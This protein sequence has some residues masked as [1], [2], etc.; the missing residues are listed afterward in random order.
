MLTDAEKFKAV[1]V[2]I[3]R[4]LEELD[5]VPD[6]AVAALEKYDAKYVVRLLHVKVF[7][8]QNALIERLREIDPAIA[9]ELAKRLSDGR[10]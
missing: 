9:E 7:D 10:A 4:L 8:L 5:K 3:D 1:K 6:Q 2:E